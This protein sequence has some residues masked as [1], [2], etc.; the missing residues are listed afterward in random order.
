M[1]E[2][3]ISLNE[4]KSTIT[5]FYIE[6]INK[7]NLEIFKILKLNFEE[8]KLIFPLI[9]FIISRLEA[10]IV[11]TISDRVWDAEI[12]LRSAIETLIKFIFISS[13]ENGE[14]EKRLNEYWYQLA[15]VNSIKQSEQAKKNLI[16]F[17]EIETIRLAFMPIV[18]PEEEENKLRDKWSKIN[19]QKLEQKWSFTEI[20]RALSKEYRGEQMEIFSTLLQGYKISSHISHGD[21][22]GIGIIDERNSRSDEQKKFAYFSHYLRIL[23]DV[24]VFDSLIGIE[25]VSLLKIKDNFF[26]KNMDCINTIKPIEDKYKKYVFEDKDYDKYRK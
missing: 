17:G 3:L 16:H 4:D 7:N 23:N 8:I 21:E 26:I 18:L 11:L 22:T 5:E 2:R 10:V 14:R 12:V 13:A 15:E 9:E 1:D 19:R 24:F 25:I 20:I 6:L